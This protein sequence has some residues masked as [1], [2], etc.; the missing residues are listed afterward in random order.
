ML[1]FSVDIDQR[2]T[3]T[4]GKIFYCRSN[5]KKEAYGVIHFKYM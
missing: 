4:N 1:S 2:D 3:P 5:N